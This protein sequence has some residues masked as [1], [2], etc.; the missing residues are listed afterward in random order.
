MTRAEYI[1][2]HTPDVLTAS[3]DTGLLPSVFMAQAILESSD[4]NGVPGNSSLAKKY[5]NHFGIKASNGWKGQTATLPTKEQIG[6]EVK[7]ISAMFR[8]YPTP[9]DSFVDRAKFLQSNPR[10]ANAGVFSA[11]TPEEQALRLYKAGYAT[12]SNYPAKIMNLINANGLK[13]LDALAETEKKKEISD[14]QLL[15]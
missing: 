10:Y 8:A 13:K 7:T 2:L 9:K 6:A 1:T 3:K 14:S 11:K 15:S 4:S 12:D 5:N